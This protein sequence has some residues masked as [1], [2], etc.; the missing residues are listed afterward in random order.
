MLCF[1]FYP[2]F[3]PLKFFFGLGFRA[4]KSLRLSAFLGVFFPS[5]LYRKA[6]ELSASE[7]ER[8]EKMVSSVGFRRYD[9]P[10]RRIRY[11]GDAERLAPTL[12]LSFFWKIKRWKRVRQSFFSLLLN[13]ERNLSNKKFVHPPTS[14]HSSFLPFPFS[15]FSG[16]HERVRNTWMKK[17]RK[18]GAKGFNFFAFP[19]GL[20]WLL[21]TSQYNA[22]MIHAPTMLL[23]DN[24]I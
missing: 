6:L 7:S 14:P 13:E 2:F 8:E 20:K 15:F 10:V 16:P 24:Q 1:F 21:W 17:K 22:A 4:P 23:Y 18:M 9:F 12:S 3:C 19:D 5:R 11:R